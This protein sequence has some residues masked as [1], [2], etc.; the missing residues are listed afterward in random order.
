MAMSV[1]RL[2]GALHLGQRPVRRITMMVTAS[3][4]IK[5]SPE[6]PSFLIPPIPPQ[7][8]EPVRKRERGHLPVPRRIMRTEKIV[9]EKTDNS[10]IQRTA[11]RARRR[12]LPL[13]FR[14]VGPKNALNAGEA[15]YS[16]P[17]LEEKERP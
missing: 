6:A 9:R 14:K 4:N 7:S 11:P 8:E 15:R 3:R 2:F 5:L 13:N 16:G 1:I 10:F 12:R 17:S